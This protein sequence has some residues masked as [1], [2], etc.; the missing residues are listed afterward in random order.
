LK[1]PIDPKTGRY[2]QD[3]PVMR[4]SYYL[5]EGQEV[6]AGYEVDTRWQRR[7]YQ[8]LEDYLKEDY[9]LVIR[10]EEIKPEERTGNVPEQGWV[11]ID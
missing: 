6:P 11:Y 3:D 8:T 2:K 9:V 4:E 1:P 10:A 5:E 7:P